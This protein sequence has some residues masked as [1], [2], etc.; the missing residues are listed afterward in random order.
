MSNQPNHEETQMT[1]QTP[2]P[3]NKRT[4]SEEIEVAGN[5]LLEKVNELV[6]QG[7][8]RR[9]IIRDQ[10]DRALLEVPLTIG[11]VAGGAL[12]IF[13]APLAAIGALAALV[14]RVKLEIVREEPAATV[15]D[16][17]QAAD[18]AADKL[19]NDE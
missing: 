10:N 14:A 18:D 1:T 17:K 19:K 5:Q 13:A 7:N 8:V 4:F 15:T 2:Q 9:L 12:A 6:Q 11:A 16:V 3:H